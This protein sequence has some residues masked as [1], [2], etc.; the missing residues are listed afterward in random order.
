MIRLM[1]MG[2]SWP[3]S[4]LGNDEITDVRP[5]LLPK[6]PINVKYKSGCL[7]VWEKNKAAMCI[8]L[9]RHCQLLNVQAPSKTQRNQAGSNS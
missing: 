2:A 7:K 5:T 3:P 1:F 6:I 9:L 4:F 8:S